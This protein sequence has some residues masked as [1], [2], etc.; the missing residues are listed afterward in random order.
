MVAA[1]ASQ[2]LP[3]QRGRPELFHSLKTEPLD[4]LF[5]HRR[6]RAALHL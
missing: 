2:E 6:A 4:Q 5:S 1:W 3:Q